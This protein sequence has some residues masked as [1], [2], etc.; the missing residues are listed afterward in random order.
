MLHQLF[1]QNHKLIKHALPFYRQNGSTLSQLFESLWNIFE[2]AITDPA[3]GETLIFLDAL[4]ECEERTR[5]ALVRKFA[6]L[7]SSDQHKGLLKL[8]ITSRPSTQLGD[9]IWRGKIDPASINLT[10]E[11]EVEMEAIRSEIDLVIRE[12][13]KHFGELRKYRG[14]EDSAHEILLDHLLQVDN[15]TYL[16]VTLVLPELERI[17]GSSKKKLL[18]AIRTVPQTVNDAYERILSRSTDSTLATK[19][20]QLVLGAVRPLT[21]NEMNVALSIT[22]DSRCLADLD[23]ESSSSFRT[24]V[25]DLCGLFVNIRDSRIYLLHQTA[26]EFLL[27]RRDHFGRCNLSVRWQQSMDAAICN[28][29]IAK[30][31]LSFLSFSDFET[32]PSPDLEAGLVEYLG[33]YPFLEYA[34]INWLEHVRSFTDLEYDENEGAI[35]SIC[36]PSSRGCHMWLQIHYNA[37]NKTAVDRLP[38][39]F[40][41][42]IIAAYSGLNRMFS[43]L[44]RMGIRPDVTDHHSGSALWWALEKGHED[45]ACKLLMHHLFRPKLD[46]L[47]ALQFSCIL[48]R[49]SVVECLLKSFEVNGHDKANDG[50]TAVQRTAAYGTPRILDV[51]LDYDIDKAPSNTKEIALSHAVIYNNFET[52]QYLIKQDVNLEARSANGTTVLYSSVANENVGMAQLLLLAGAKPDN[53]SSNPRNKKDHNYGETALYRAASIYNVELVSLLLEHA[54][55]VEVKNGGSE[56]AIYRAVGPHSSNPFGLP[57]DETC[58]AAILEILLERGARV[59]CQTATGDTPIRRALRAGSEPA[60]SIM[61]DFAKKSGLDIA[62]IVNSPKKVSTITVLCRR[63]FA[64]I[65][66]SNLIN[67]ETF[68]D[69]ILESVEDDHGPSLNVPRDELFRGIRMYDGL[70]RRLLHAT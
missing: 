35:V 41:E 11:N 43:S 60:K 22:E 12:K 61:E 7:F 51:L 68:R 26:K 36:N 39:G 6:S 37:T 57:V 19:L 65:E 20:L 15:R 54:A 1:S 67:A 62:P 33:R 49:V 14:I 42:Y 16:W 63:H 53:L 66:E 3:A 30:I 32:G 46:A 17:A 9:E 8:L 40:N 44:D 47:T 56:T 58:Q 31:C 2:I 52:A 59:D 4:D 64:M 69:K 55:D 21:L 27:Q 24:T 5:T 28:I 29:T 10:G 70:V 38:K 13:I 18:E 23:L 34:S 25:R 50:W 48:G 45:T